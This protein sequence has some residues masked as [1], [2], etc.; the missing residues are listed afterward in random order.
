MCVCVCIPFQKECIPS[1]IHTQC[2]CILF[3][4]RLLQ[5]TEY[6][7][8]CY[9]VGPYWLSILYMHACSVA[10]LCMTLRPHWPGSSVR[11]ILQARILEWVAIS[12]S[13]GSSQTR[14]QTHIYCIGRRILYHCTTREVVILYI[15]VKVLV[16]ESC[17]ILCDPMDCSPWG[18]LCPW[19]SPGKNTG[20][21]S[22]SL[23]QA[24]FPTQESYPGLLHCRQIYYHLSH[25]GSPM[26][27]C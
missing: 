12:F 1:E 13:M 5:V 6:S 8:L 19:N 9:T 2:V 10:E 14:D 17:P 21:G 7:S 25:Q 16:A 20:V 24:I 15:V 18:L 27:I 4:H 23:L 22:H 3:P 26:C 11:G